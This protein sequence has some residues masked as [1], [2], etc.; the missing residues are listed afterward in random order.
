MEARDMR[1]AARVRRRAGFTLLEVMVALAIF[2]VGLLA[3]VP[4][5]H[6]ATFG[7]RNGRELSVATNLARTYVD[8]IRNT[9]YGNI[10]TEA[11]CPAACA[12]PAAEVTDNA[13]Y[14]VT[15]SMTGPNG[16][17]YSPAAVPAIKRVTVRVVCPTCAGQTLRSTGITMTTLVAER[18]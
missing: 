2:S 5:F 10:G 9:P 7:V 11:G 14:V 18:S 16:G 8:K 4:L 3:M 15:W 6:M 12:P 17:A 13:P 1:T